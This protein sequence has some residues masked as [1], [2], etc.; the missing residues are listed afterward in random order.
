MGQRGFEVG[1][2]VR[3]IDGP[4]TDF[5]AVIKEI[6]L[7]KGKLRALV[8]VFGREVPAELGERQVKAWS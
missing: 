4:F 7:E 8:Y 3:I 1:Q 5:S 2:E 6:D